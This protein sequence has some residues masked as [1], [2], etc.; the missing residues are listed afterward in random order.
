MGSHP[1]SSE[2]RTT[3]SEKSAHTST[4]GLT[5]T[6]D[7]LMKALQMALPWVKVAAVQHKHLGRHCPFCTTI[8]NAEYALHLGE[9]THKVLE[10]E[11]G[12]DSEE[13]HA[14]ECQLKCPRLLYQ[15]QC[16]F[17]V[18]DSAGMRSGAGD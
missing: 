4:E 7:E 9:I 13:S 16:K 2:R 5:E 12:I 15:S 18:D 8:R 6:I 11:S 14:A 3:M 1:K 17:S 10:Q